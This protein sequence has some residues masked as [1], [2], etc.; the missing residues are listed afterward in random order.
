MAGTLYSIG[1]IADLAD[2][3]V[4][5]IRW[6]IAKLGIKPTYRIGGKFAYNQAAVNKILRAIATKTTPE[7][8]E[9]TETTE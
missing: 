2:Q 8:T 6:L 9:T 5:Q 1:E 3:K 4:H 7:T